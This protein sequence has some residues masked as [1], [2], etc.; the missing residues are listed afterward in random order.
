VKF[1]DSE[2]VTTAQR[3]HVHTC[4][5]KIKFAGRFVSK[6]MHNWNNCSVC[7]CI[8]SSIYSILNEA[9][10]QQH[11]ISQALTP[12]TMGE[13]RMNTKQRKKAIE[14]V[15]KFKHLILPN[16]FSLRAWIDIFEFLKYL[17]LLQLLKYIKI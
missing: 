15:Q 11:A 4:K 8:L 17:L 5:R 16:P 9:S 6:L 10:C 3:I 7:S 14:N 2:D 12:G 13:K 1:I